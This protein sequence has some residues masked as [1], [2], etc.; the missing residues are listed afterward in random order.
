MCVE[1]F[2][3]KCNEQSET[4]FLY[5]YINQYS[6]NTTSHILTIYYI[7]FKENPIK[8]QNTEL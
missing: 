3:D 2:K 1:Q 4:I 8:L 6:Y 5:I 7:S